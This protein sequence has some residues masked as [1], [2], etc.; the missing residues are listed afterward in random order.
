MSLQIWLKLK[1]K[2][3]QED[4]R[5]LLL[6]A[7]ACFLIDNGCNWLAENKLKRSAVYALQYCY[8]VRMGSEN[9]TFLIFKNEGH[10]H[11][12]AAK[13]HSAP[14]VNSIS[15]WVGNDLHSLDERGRS[16]SF[17]GGSQN[18]LQILATVDELILCKYFAYI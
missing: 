9:T 8:W 5:F 2:Y 11:F 3:R 14:E 17:K 16:C 7:V 1:V 18:H 13:V 4:S 10:Q 12:L 6:V 15:V